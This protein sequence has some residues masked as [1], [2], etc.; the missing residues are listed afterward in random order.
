[1]S[2]EESKETRA[3]SASGIGSVHTS[4][5]DLTEV[6]KLDNEAL[7]IEIEEVKNY[8]AL[9]KKN[10]EDVKHNEQ[11]FAVAFSDLESQNEKL[12]ERLSVLEGQAEL[13]TANSYDD[14]EEKMPN[15][16]KDIK[17]DLTIKAVFNGTKIT[18][19]ATDESEDSIS[20]TPEQRTKY[21]TNFLTVFFGWEKK[22]V[23]VD[24]PDDQRI[25]VPF[26]VIF[27]NWDF[28]KKN[29]LD[30]VNED[31]KANLKEKLQEL[32][33]EVKDNILSP[34]ISPTPSP[35]IARF[36]SGSRTPSRSPSP[37]SFVD[38]LERNSNI[39]SRRVESPTSLLTSNG[40]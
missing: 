35:Q 11:I 2:R 26:T 34:T 28:N 4:T 16:Q 6:S 5:S 19:T 30:N 20:V 12:K 17:K 13:R 25:L 38:S 9:I 37:P 27:N 14:N 40:R 33:V 7:R 18:F 22:P 21:L 29:N 8:L 23:N 1:M 39:P 32:G 3:R 10:L 31:H 15:S 24:Y 36:P